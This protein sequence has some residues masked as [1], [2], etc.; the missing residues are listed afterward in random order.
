MYFK[1]ESG[2]KFMSYYIKT[3]FPFLFICFSLIIAIS[4]AFALYWSISYSPYLDT[5]NISIDDSN[6]NFEFS[7]DKVEYNQLNQYL[8]IQ[9]W[10]F[11]K[12]ED[13]KNVSSYYVLYDEQESKYIRL[14]SKMV[15]RNDVPKN[16][17]VGYKI[18]NCGIA[19]MI[20]INKLNK[21]HTYKIYVLYGN[22]D[23]NILVYMHKKINGIG[24]I[25]K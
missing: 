20:K 10:V 21:T 17:K 5:S 6:L 13:I 12:D 23:N 7:V 1:I 16:L 22:N 14:P 18:S 15:T 8:I 3:N 9:G 2:D 19:S 11:K 4:F 24:D 25:I